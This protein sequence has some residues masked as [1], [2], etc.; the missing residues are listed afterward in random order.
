VNEKL[1][2]GYDSQPWRT[3]FGGG[4]ALWSATGFSEGWDARSGPGREGAGALGFLLGGGQAD[5]EAGQTT[6]ALA[7]RFTAIARAAIPALPA[8]NGKLRRTAW[9]RDP[10][11]RGAY[12][13][14]RPGQLMRFAPLLTRE[15]GKTSTASRSG[16]I[17]FAGEWVSDEWPGYMNGAAQTGRIAADAVIADVRQSRTSRPSSIRR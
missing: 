9:W 1:V 7:A 2:V 3:V 13:N 11:S 10:L 14:F 15:A 8:P 12:V 4:G 5:A 17:L 16:N 6:Q